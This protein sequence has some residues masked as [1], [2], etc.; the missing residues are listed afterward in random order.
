MEKKLYELAVNPELKEFMTPLSGTEL[1]ALEQNIIANGCRTPVIVWDGVIVDGHH[2]YEICHKHGIPFAIEE[3][4]FAD[5]GEAKL[6]MF[7]EQRSHRNMNE[8]ERIVIALKCK[9]ILLEKGRENQGHRSDLDFL[10][11]GTK[12][13][14]TRQMI[15]DMAG[16]SETMVHKVEKI[17]E[18]ADDATKAALRDG[19]MK[20]GTAYNKWC[21][22]KTEKHSDV[23]P[24]SA[25]KALLFLRDV[26]AD[27]EEGLK[28]FAHL[29]NYANSSREMD[30]KILKIMSENEAVSSDILCRHIINL[31]M[32]RKLYEADEDAE[33]IVSAHNEFLRSVGMAGYIM[34]GLE[35]Y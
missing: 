6:W 16:A 20:V 27:F 21:K 2:R 9:P 28:E 10:F 34:P 25:G 8:V 11:K 4:E 23:P 7:Q 12:S 32:Q 18:A 19:S 33:H 17:W 29:Y 22:K 13:H 14:N 3:Q 26:L 15:A 1:A 30:F 35:E 24:C 5:L 31:P